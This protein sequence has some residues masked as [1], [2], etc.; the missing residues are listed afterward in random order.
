MGLEVKTVKCPNC[1]ASLSV[2]E[3]RK[4]I[5]CSYCGSKLQL[6][7]SNEYTVNIR[8]EAEIK[9]AETNRII[10]LK[11]LE[12]AEKENKWRASG[13]LIAL[14]F[15]VVGVLMLIIAYSGSYH[16]GLMLG[17]MICLVAAMLIWQKDENEF[18]FGDGDRIKI[19]DEVTDYE[20][21][22]YQTVEALLRGVGFTDVQSVGL[23]DLTIGVLKRPGRVE[24]ITINGKRLNSYGAKAPKDAHIII[25]YHSQA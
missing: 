23:G 19:P 1:G 2:E 5:F 15:L 8:D 24:S 20:K 13:K 18:G 3:G 6:H 11:Q 21:K 17:G 10:Q 7:D 4:S 16:M 14:A 22:S 12:K 25:S 9:N